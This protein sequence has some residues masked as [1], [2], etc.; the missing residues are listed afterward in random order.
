MATN[1]SI[2]KT[3][4]TF[5]ATTSILTP[6]LTTA[7]ATGADSALRIG[8]T[9]FAQYSALFTGDGTSY[10]S[11]STNPADVAFL[12]SAAGKMRISDA[13]L[14]GSA[15]LE[16]NNIHSFGAFDLNIDSATN[17][18]NFSLNSITGVSNLAATSLNAA[19]LTNPAGD[20]ILSGIANVQISPA[21]DLNVIA[22][23]DV[24]L[25]PT[26]DIIVQTGKQLRVDTITNVANNDFVD[27]P[28]GARSLTGVFQADTGTFTAALNSNSLTSI[29]GT[30]LSINPGSGQTVSIGNSG[31]LSLA[32]DIT[33]AGANLNIT[34]AGSA[35]ITGN[36]VFRVTGTTAGNSFFE[37]MIS[38]DSAARASF[39]TGTNQTA[40]SLAKGDGTGTYLSYLGTAGKLTISSSSVGTG[41]GTLDT[42]TGTILAE[43]FTRGSSGFVLDNTNLTLSG[44]TG[45]K[46]PTSGGTATALNY[47]ERYTA[48]VSLTGIWAS[49][50]NCTIDI[51]R[52]GTSV[53]MRIYGGV[54]ATATVA[55]D[56]T[57]ATGSIPTRF[58]GSNEATWASFMRQ[59]F[60]VRDNGTDKQGLFT[61]YASGQFQI[62]VGYSTGGA[63]AG[64]GSSGF[65]GQS[66]PWSL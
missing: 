66:I 21:G 39:Y 23:G 4:D 7:T 63:F 26:N 37:G 8:K 27:F 36:G 40:L 53:N 65:S 20:L 32:N 54:L 49:P 6:L 9:G 52:V 22:G 44:S 2:N 5:V 11:D 34:S 47:Y 42:N 18:V 29:S 64:S 60:V 62:S 57:C 25:N 15:T 38:G 33:I 30:G 45:I 46:F 55:T 17:L 56:I 43:T 59:S 61:I 1:N 35:L 58:L 41:A 13:T 12:R 51:T 10:Y 50:Q 28:N 19:S 48:T 14:T 24:I 3:S 16:V 31:K